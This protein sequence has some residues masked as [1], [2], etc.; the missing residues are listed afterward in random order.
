MIKISIY[1]ESHIGY[2]GSIKNVRIKSEDTSYDINE[3]VSE[4]NASFGREI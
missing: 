1:S 2:R 4:K 3:L